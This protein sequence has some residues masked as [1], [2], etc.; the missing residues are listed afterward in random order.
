MRIFS[1]GMSKESGYTFVDVI[2]SLVI[3]GIALSPLV[4]GLSSFS[5]NSA[6][7]KSEIIGYAEKRTEA[8]LKGVYIEEIVTD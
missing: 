3:V 1:A 2:I 4:S 5:R 7:V 6:K 8:Q